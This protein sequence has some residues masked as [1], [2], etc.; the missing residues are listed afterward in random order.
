MHFGKEI[1]RN[2]IAQWDGQYLD[3][4]VLKKILKTFK[5]KA[6]GFDEQFLAAYEKEM[7]KVNTFFNATVKELQERL[8]SVKN[9]MDDP[10]AKSTIDKLGEDAVDLEKY[11]LMNYTGFHKILKKHLRVT[12]STSMAALRRQIDKQDFYMSSDLNQIAKAI[13]DIQKTLHSSSRVS[14]TLKHERDEDESPVAKKVRKSS[15]GYPGR[16]IVVEGLDGSGKSTQLSLLHERLEQEGYTV[17]ITRWNSSPLLSMTIKKVKRNRELTPVTFT[18]MQATD[19][20]ETVLKVITPALERGEV[21]LCD[22]Y[23]YTSL[24]RD[25][26]RGSDPKWLRS[27]YTFTLQPDLVMYFKVP[28]ET[29]IGRVMKRRINPTDDDDSDGS[30]AE[31][32]GKKEK[33]L[34]NYY[35]AGLDLNLCDDPVQ[36]F[37]EFQKR[38]KAAYDNMAP[39][40]GF[41]VIDASRSIEEQYEEVG[42]LISHVCA[43]LKPN[44]DLSKNIFTKDP[45]ADRIDVQQN[46]AHKKRGAHFFFRNAC[47]KIQERFCQLV[48]CADVP[49]VF[50]HGNPHI[51][52]FAKTE[53]GPAMIDFDRSRDGPYCWDLF[54]MLISVSL[55]QEIPTEHSVLRQPVLDAAKS[56]YLSMINSQSLSL[57]PFRLMLNM[58]PSQP[59]EQSVSSY[60]AHN[61]KWTKDMRQ[62]AI[63]QNDPKMLA[64]LNDFL[65][66]IDRK[67]LLDEYWIEE[68][69]RTI[70]RVSEE[71][72]ERYLIVLAPRDPNSEADRIFLD[73]KKV[74]SDPDSKYFTSRWS[75]DGVRMTEASKLYCVHSSPYEGHATYQ[76]EQYWGRHIPLFNAK[77]KK[78][79]TE[80]E[81]INF[82]T[83]VAAQLGRAHR[84]ACRGDATPERI[85]THLEKNFDD[86]VKAA[87]VVKR[88]LAIAH[89][90]YLR[91]LKQ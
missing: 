31:E 37:H 46:Y 78:P 48:D 76:K 14:K 66:N 41:R 85:A 24:A 26:V 59:W 50:L 40:F 32:G 15:H 10:A 75:H 68:A 80:D 27:L 16:L 12:N 9:A 34:V 33:P 45:R 60:L 83:F 28:V 17:V 43:G 63:P 69:G 61:H 79:L 22:R 70:S 84:M 49:Q 30:D 42:S 39:E 19:L 81:Q 87:E 58:S 5:E 4:H 52:N 91:N 44:M 54:R 64:L 57:P 21:V 47:L 56:A 74:R 11:V 29:A 82:V 1:L 55:R 20:A 23:F 90:L 53:Y 8:Q 25:S 88:E 67:S 86:F 18:M 73:I 71:E 38:V 51:D 3:Y 65:G 13:E 35:E 72:R 6:P 36:N 2:V 7:T 77:L 62:S 89:R